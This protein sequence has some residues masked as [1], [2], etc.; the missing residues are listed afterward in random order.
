M[1]SGLTHR[2]VDPALPTAVVVFILALENQTSLSIKLLSKPIELAIHIR[3]IENPAIFIRVHPVALESIIY[4]ETLQGTVWRG[5]KE[6]EPSIPS[7]KGNDDQICMICYTW[8]LLHF[9]LS[10][11]RDP[12]HVALSEVSTFFLPC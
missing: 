10:W 2:V 8:H 1:K 4:I 6:N 3:S 12:S 9:C 11:E 5:K 7:P